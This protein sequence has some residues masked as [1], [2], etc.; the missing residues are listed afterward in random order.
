MG[1]NAYERYL[2][3]FEAQHG[4]GGVGDAGEAGDAHRPM[5]EKEFWRAHADD[6]V[7]KGCC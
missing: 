4:A 5:T 2:A 3:R 1:A 6:A 7:P